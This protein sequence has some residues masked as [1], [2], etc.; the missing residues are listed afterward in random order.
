MKLVLRV[1]SM[2]LFVVGIIW[3]IARPGFDAL[4]AFIT[5]FLTLLTS[6]VVDK[7]SESL[8]TAHQNNYDSLSEGKYLDPDEANNQ[9]LLNLVPILITLRL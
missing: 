6:F 2:L 8:K 3:M 7:P 9:Y 1:V 5:G 4:T